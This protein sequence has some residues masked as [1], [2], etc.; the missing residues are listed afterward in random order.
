MNILIVRHGQ[1]DVNLERRLQGLTDNP[2]N[3]TGREQAQIAKQKLEDEPIDLI[4]C[5]PLVRARETADIINKGRNIK[6]IYDDRIIERDF[7][8][9][10]GDYIKNYDMYEFWSYKANKKYEKAENIKE[11]FSKIYSFLD[12]IKEKYKGKNILLV[13]HS[14]VSIA[15]KCYFEGIPED[16]KL[17][18]IRL[19]NCEIAKYEV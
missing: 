4:I 6:I 11:F 8:E 17:V 19:K 9:F 2:L 7:G 13:A 12:D 10:E 15:V 1:T 18:E 5:S 3:D 14:G 16:D